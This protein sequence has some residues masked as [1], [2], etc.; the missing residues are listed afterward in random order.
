MKKK[1]NKISLAYAESTIYHIYEIYQKHDS[2]KFNKYVHAL[3]R[4]EALDGWG[5]KV[6]HHSAYNFSCGFLFMDENKEI[7]LYYIGSNDSEHDYRYYQ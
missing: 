5:F 6:I 2:K 4:M 1:P 3:R 7:R